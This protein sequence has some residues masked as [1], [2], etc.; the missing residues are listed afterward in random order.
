MTLL[1]IDLAGNINFIIRRLAENIYNVVGYSYI[2]VNTIIPVLFKRE[3]RKVVGF[4]IN[5]IIRTYLYKENPGDGLQLMA[6]FPNLKC[7]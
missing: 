4:S 7:V 1:C 3:Y 2:S 6:I 5:F